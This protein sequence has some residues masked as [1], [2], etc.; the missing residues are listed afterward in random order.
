VLKKSTGKPNV[1]KSVIFGTR[2]IANELRKGKAGAPISIAQVFIQ[3]QTQRRHRKASKIA[4]LTG[5]Y[6]C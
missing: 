5:V 2:R 1:Q 6:G 4:I 3:A